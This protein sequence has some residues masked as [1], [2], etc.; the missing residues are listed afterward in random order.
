MKISRRQVLENGLGMSALLP[1]ISTPGVASPLL[2][3]K[4]SNVKPHFVVYFQVY[5]AWDVCLAMDPKDRE[6][7]L[8]NGAK[9][10][11]QPYAMNEVKEK[12]G[13][14]F[15]PAMMGLMPYAGK[16]CIVN[17]I[18]M[19]L[20]NGHSPMN[21]MTGVTQGSPQEKASLQALVS[22]NH[23]FISRLTI[24]HVYASYDGYFCAGEFGAQTVAISPADAKKVLGDRGGAQ[25]LRWARNLMGIS[26]DS[27][28]EDQRRQ[29][30]QY[31]KNL[32]LSAS[33]SQTL[34]QG[35]QDTDAD[36]SKISEMAR[37]FGKLFK[38]KVLGSLTISLGEKFF[39]DT[40]FQHYKNHPLLAALD[41]VK[42]FC[43]QLSAI[44]FDEHSSVFDHTTVVVTAEY[45]R[46]PLL[47]GSEGKD[48]NFRTNSL[49]LLGKNIQSKTFG[50]SGERS[51]GGGLEAH[52]GLPIDFATGRYNSQ[53]EILKMRNIWS[54]I[55]PVFSTDLSADF[56]RDVKSVGFFGA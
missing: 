14:L 10:F 7:K 26:P 35:E 13:L 9:A 47:N 18:D 36:M 20:D 44:G 32:D 56:G 46:T 41:E 19:E 38:Q 5:G 48:H 11:D 52:A 16:L 50:L 34:S 49:L 40:H 39:F 53:G 1:F 2:G 27:H 28:D 22:G 37:F 54:G 29:L 23:S 6:L 31:K 30:L 25:N 42:E 17:G 4:F 24:P 8:S 21:A 33:L 43:D 55:G 3:E 15:G 12:S 51:S 45:A